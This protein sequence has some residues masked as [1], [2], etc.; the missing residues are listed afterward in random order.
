MKIKFGTDGWRAIIAKDF[1]FENVEKLSQ[2]VSNYLLSKKKNPKVVV[3]F[4]TR[5][6]S[7]EF[8]KTSSQVFCRNNISVVLSENFLPTPALSFKTKKGG[9]DLGIMITA[10]HNPYYFNGYKIK[11]PTGGAADVN[12]TQEIEALIEKDSVR[13]M[14]LKEAQN[15][16]LLKIE[17]FRSEYIK[18]LRGYV[19]LKVLKKKRLKVCID[20]MHG[21]CNRIFGELVKGTNVE[22]SFIRDQINPYFEGG[23][24]EPIEENLKRLKGEIK[25]KKFDLGLAFDG[26]GDRISAFTEKGE[27]IHPQVL[28]PLLC[29]YLYNS[30]KWRGS[31]VKTV[32]GSLLIDKVCKELNL[33]IREVPIGFKYISTVFEKEEVLIGGEEAGGIGFKNYIPER[34]GSL[35]GLLLLEMMATYR[36]RISKLLKELYKRYGKFYYLR[37]DLPLSKK[38]GIDLE[39]IKFP[40]SLLGRKVIKINRLDGVK[41]ITPQSWLMFRKSGTEPLVRIYA[42]AKS[43]KEAV[44][45]IKLGKKLLAK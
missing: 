20:S 1:T 8:A 38:D 3:G 24:P 40:S 31:V 10:S 17:N 21:A 44:E 33:P 19:D 42:E 28:L 32:V 43:K 25:T 15:I 11:K 13:K 35:A 23:R 2:A 12:L 29:E 16:G 27:F 6:L 45:L 37:E 4:D 34:D 36:K 18:F 22:L 39:K 14:E 26:D 30:R 41:L 5:F 7:Q 9:F